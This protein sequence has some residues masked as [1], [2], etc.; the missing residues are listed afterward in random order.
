MIKFLYP[1][2]RVAVVTKTLRCPSKNIYSIKDLSFLSN[3][4]L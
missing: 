2:A 1:Q 3:P 4:A